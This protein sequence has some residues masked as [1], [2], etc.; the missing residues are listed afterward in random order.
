MRRDNFKKCSNHIVYLTLVELTEKVGLSKEINVGGELAKDS[1]PSQ[2]P[3]VIHFL[4]SLLI[5][6]T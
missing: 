4:A 6:S 1:T 5:S 2:T 3:R